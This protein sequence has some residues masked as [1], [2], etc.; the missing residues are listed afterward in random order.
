MIYITG[1]IGWIVYSIN[2]VSGPGG[3]GNAFFNLLV[4]QQHA[5]FGIGGPGPVNIQKKDKKHAIFILGI[6][7]LVFLCG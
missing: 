2:V 1:G 6:Q 5:L 3:H 7:V 4:F